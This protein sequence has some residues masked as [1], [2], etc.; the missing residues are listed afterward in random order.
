MDTSSSADLILTSKYSIGFDKYSCI[1]MGFIYNGLK[2]MSG[3]IQ[4]LKD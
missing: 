3:Y 2:M 4:Y 1:L